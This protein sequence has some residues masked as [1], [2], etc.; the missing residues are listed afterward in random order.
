MICKINF[1][2]LNWKKTLLLYKLNN[3]SF[4]AISNLAIPLRSS[5]NTSGRSKLNL[6]R[7]TSQCPSKRRSIKDFLSL[8]PWRLS[9][10]KKCKTLIN[11]FQKHWS[12]ITTASD[13]MTL[14]SGQKCFIYHYEEKTLLFLRK[15]INLLF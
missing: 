12:S 2:I 15:S 5:D 13:W 8:F 3:L 6:A 4:S 14:H 10:F 9:L 7:H 1:Y 11:S